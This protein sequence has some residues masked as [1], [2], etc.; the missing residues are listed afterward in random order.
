MSATYL[1]D[2]RPGQAA[3]RSRPALGRL[4]ALAAGAVALIG[5]FLPWVRYQQT[6]FSGAELASAIAPALAGVRSGGLKGF[7]IALHAVPAL[8]IVTV[9]CA[10]LSLRRRDQEDEARLSAWAGAAALAGLAIALLFVASALLPGAPGTQFSPGLVRTDA[11]VQ[12]AAPRALNAGDL[13]GVG[14]GAYLT[15]VAFG[16]AAAGGLLAA[17]GRAAA[18]RSAWRTQDFVLLAVLAVVF[19]ALYWW[20]LQPYLWIAPL[21]AQP[22][23]ELLFGIWFVAG[24]LGGYIIRRP[25]AAFLA[26]SMAALAEVL[27]G[28]PAGP[29]LVVT[30]VMQALG[31]EL[32]FAATGYRR[33]G[34]TTMALAGVA[35]GLVALPWNW[36]RLGYFALDPSFLLL[37]LA[38]RVA[39]GALAGAL[40]KLLGDLL[41]A[42]GGLNYFAI[43][44]EHVREV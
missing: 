32:V 37:L 7:H 25:G 1:P 42:T 40:A 35:A 4:V 33:W 44:R 36:F 9:A 20:W 23:Q 3:G 16:A 6:S 34:W 15:T 19:G 18:V 22:G 31:P 26:E 24:L 39:S 21:A 14:P 8:A 29:I 13:V 28:A 43:G 11:A 38:V 2:A 27:L 41:A 17:R 12:A 5:F 10:A 30:G